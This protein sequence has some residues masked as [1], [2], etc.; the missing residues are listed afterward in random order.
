MVDLLKLFW[1]RR[2]IVEMNAG[3]LPVKRAEENYFRLDV[4][5][6]TDYF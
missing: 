6:V 2:E 1:D 5:I 4:E 3:N